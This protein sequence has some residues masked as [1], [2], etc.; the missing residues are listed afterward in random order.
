[1]HQLIAL[2]PALVFLGGALVHGQLQAGQALVDRG[3]AALRRGSGAR[4][5]GA[6]RVADAG[7]RPRLAI[8][9]PL[10]CAAHRGDRESPLRR[11]PDRP[12]AHWLPRR[13]RRAGLRRRHR[14]RHLRELHLPARYRRCA[15][16]V[17][18]GA[19]TGNRRAPRRHHGGRRDVGKTIADSHPRS[20][21]PSSR[22]W[23]SPS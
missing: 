19:R 2:A 23:P 20:R 5:R 11:R 8:V 4:L 3:G 22:A 12:R 10:C 17:V 14:L 6:A 21:W 15:D 13:C 7:R 1:M 9:L 16:G 18:G